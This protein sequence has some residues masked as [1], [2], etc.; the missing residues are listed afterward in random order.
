MKNKIISL[1]SVLFALLAV[2][3]NAANLTG[4]WKGTGRAID[5]AG[6]PI[7]CESVVLSI[8]HSASSLTVNSAFTCGGQPM[9]IPGGAMEI[10]GGELFDKGVKA[11]TI[12]DSAISLVARSKGYVMQ[13]NAT[14]ND[15]VMNLRS[16]I[17]V[18]NNPAPAL[19][20]DAQ[21]RR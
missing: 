17:S 20:F 14:F 11:G 5:N 2:N 13:T 18:G 21:L 15:S 10:R 9:S 19:T 16:V 8:S 3:A 1:G 6:K 4:T 7:D 12:S